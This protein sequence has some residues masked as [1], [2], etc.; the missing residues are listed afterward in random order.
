[1]NKLD[2]RYVDVM[3]AKDAFLKAA[4]ALADYPIEDNLAFAIV[5]GG[6]GMVHATKADDDAKGAEL[7]GLVIAAA[8]EKR[9][10]Q[11]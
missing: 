4:A 6:I 10:P 5:M 11:E 2:Q 1:M 3:R 9:E 7:A 8:L